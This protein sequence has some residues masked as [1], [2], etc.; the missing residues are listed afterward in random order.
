MSYANFVQA[1]AATALTAD[2]ATITL[3]AAVA[4]YQLP[5][6]DGGVLVLTDSFYKPSVLEVVRYTA[7]VGLELHGVLRGQEGTSA[8]AWPVAPYCYQALTAGAFAAAVG[9]PT[10][11]SYQYDA[12][13]QIASSTELVNGELRVSSYQYDAG[14]NLS[15][16]TTEFRGVVRTETYTYDASGNLTGMTAVEASQ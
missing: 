4:P 14:G 16:V 15:S 11:S 10:S 2:A 6:E 3:L 9:A 8:V 5:P 1:Q 13:G 12:A 7:R